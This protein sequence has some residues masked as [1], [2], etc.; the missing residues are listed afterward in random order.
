MKFTDLMQ[1]LYQDQR[2]GDFNP[3]KFARHIKRGFLGESFMVD[4]KLLIPRA[5]AIPLQ[6]DH[7]HYFH[8][9]IVLPNATETD[10]LKLLRRVRR[11]IH[12]EVMCDQQNIDPAS[13]EGDF[14]F[15]QGRKTI[16]QNAFCAG[17]NFYSNNQTE[18][19]KALGHPPEPHEIVMIG[20]DVLARDA[21]SELRQS[22]SNLP[23]QDKENVRDPESTLLRKATRALE[24][25]AL[26]LYLTLEI[27]I[28]WND[29]EE[30]P[31]PHSQINS[32]AFTIADGAPPWTSAY[33]AAHELCHAMIGH[34]FTAGKVR[35]SHDLGSQV[36]ERFALASAEL[37][38]RM[39]KI[40]SDDY[41]IYD[42]YN[43]DVQAG[44][45]LYRMLQDH[46]RKWQSFSEQHR[47]NYKT[48]YVYED[49]CNYYAMRQAVFANE[50]ALM[51]LVS[52]KMAELCDELEQET[53]RSL[54][55]A[56]HQKNYF[57]NP[58]RNKIFALIQKD[59]PVIK[60]PTKSV[61]LI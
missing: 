41:G 27:P 11:A 50:P 49:V 13:Q 23:T 43:K 29:R 40:V 5:D 57:D 17:L 6:L 60:F 47:E 33:I 30:N 28:I 52:P 3:E 45:R 53:S 21:V 7:I 26:D 42:E 48:H 38:E 31:H 24:P 15:V 20:E 55:V 19:E 32:G 35:L 54:L 25:E 56:K 2:G 4:E 16:G 34:D 10:Q 12:T 8:R 18:I 39:Q 22:A 14:I 36:P 58:M 59:D 51:R 61:T 44:E 46:I 1:R 9:D 37:N